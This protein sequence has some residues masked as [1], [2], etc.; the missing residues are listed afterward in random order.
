MGEFPSG[1]RGQT[2]NLL[3]MPSV[4]RI[5]LP[6]PEKS[7]AKAALFS[8]MCSALAERDVHFVRN[9]SFGH[10]IR[11]ARERNTSHHFAAKPQTI[12]VCTA[13]CTTCAGGANITL[14]VPFCL[15]GAGEGTRFDSLA[16]G[17]CGDGRARA[18]AR[19][20]PVSRRRF[21][22][23][24]AV[25][26]VISRRSSDRPENPGRGKGCPLP[27]RGSRRSSAASPR[28]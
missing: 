21:T 10:D 11:F 26:L 12:T 25:C 24:A 15:V 22:F 9:V 7:A 4:V 17:D 18:F 3:A 16:T 14:L 2:V 13:N 20:Y 1:Q 6:P 23:S 19:A 5:H 8:T 28:S 27:A